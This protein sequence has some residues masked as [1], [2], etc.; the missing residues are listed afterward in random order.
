M[1]QSAIDS[2]PA[3]SVAHRSS[4][5]YTPAELVATKAV[6]RRP[7]PRSPVFGWDN[8][9]ASPGFDL[10]GVES[11]P[12]KL[13]TTSGRAAIYQ[14]LLQLRLPA[15]SLI[16]VP[17]YHCP[18]MVAPVLLA[19]AKPGYFGITTAGLPD[20]ARIPTQVAQQA[21]AILV[22]HYFG[23]PQSLAEVRRW[24]DTHHIALIEDCAHSLYGDAGERCVGAWGDFATASLSKFLPVPEAG[25][26]ASG[27]RTL[28]P[29]KLPRQ[30]FKAQLKG[31]VDVL[32]LATQHQ[33]LPG[34]NGLIGSV[35][36]AQKNLRSKPLASQPNDTAVTSTTDYM[37]GCNMQR[38]HKAPLWAS[39]MIANALPQRRI[40]TRRLENYQIYASM[41]HASNG[42]VALKPTISDRAAPYV[43]PLW[44]DDADRVYHSLRAQGYPVFRWDRIW[45]GTPKMD[46]DVGPLWSQH[47]LQLL[48]HQDLCADD[49]A[50]TAAAVL[51]L[52]K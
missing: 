13:H 29:V 47:V 27:T 51:R 8:F 3:A 46:G 7:M 25:L 20:I 22:P 12:Y 9:H 15:G 18:T 37:L 21:K 16:L 26:L 1:K 30:G 31:F 28:A 41:L 48:C 40:V 43:F 24:C 10:N 34:L 44:V 6:M 5:V 19:N 38:S 4:T 49:I 23:L 39:M 11:L 50:Q 32:D 33:R 36:R 45:P 42:A 17:T 52:L 2:V 14:A 35:F